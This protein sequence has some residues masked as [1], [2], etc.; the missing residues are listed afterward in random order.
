MVD[1]IG[2]IE[3]GLN[4][5]TYE[6]SVYY[7]NDNY[8]NNIT[9]IPFAVSKADISLSIEVL[10]KVYTA[11]IEG[12]VF[13]NV[14]GEY[15]VLIDNKVIKV[16]VKN[17][18]GSFNVGILSAGNYSAS[19]SFKGNDK[20]NAALN[21][22]SFEVTSTGT[23]FYIV[24]NSSEIT[25]GDDIRLSQSLPAD[26]TGSVTYKFA[27]GTVIKVVD[28][29]E[30]FVLSGLDAGSYVIYADYSGDDNYAPAQDSI[31]IIV[32][33]PV[34]YIVVS[35][36]DLTKYYGGSEKLTVNVSD[37]RGIV[38]AGKKVIININGVNYT[39]T[40]D[41]NGIASIA[42]NLTSG[43]YIAVVYVDDVVMKVKI[44][45]LA[46]VNGTDIIKV[47]RNGTQYYATF[48]D[49]Q[50]N[51]LPDGTAVQFNVNGVFYERAISGNEG[52]A[53]LNINLHQGEY[54]ITA[55][56]P[57]TGEMASNHIIV[58][59]RLVNN[60]NLVKYFRNESQY[61]VK[62]IDDD[63]NPMG[64]GVSVT[65]N[66]NGVFYTR[67]TNESGI[68]K[69][70]INLEPGDYII[71]AEYE[72]CK[73]SNSIKVLPILH[74]SDLIKAY[75]TPDQFVANLLDG[76]GNPYANQK[77]QFNING[78]FYYRTTD[79]SGN[80]RLNINLM[81]GQYIITSSYNGMNIANTVKVTS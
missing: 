19:V 4:A 44:T 55:M 57:V 72:E 54:I 63:G 35:V 3:I 23:N 42:I 17:G 46:T 15:I 30:S 64:A 27:N 71:T 59:S 52:L 20:Y 77:V 22:T 11:Y 78:V 39:R 41:E 13:A 51:Y 48:R 24:V 75:R 56:N 18:I 5:G 7:V 21:K 32:D 1:G 36:D 28:V 80:A 43:E 61:T 10:D 62:V 45:V 68:A 9:S 40:T 73:V 2:K 6:A 37:N 8:E 31:T 16:T 76:Q 12:T 66:I 49:S 26:A 69:L 14:D 65:F 38:I 81:P 53:K 25:Y 58:I 29:G 79:N 34:I 60:Y 33:K 74:A 47:F 70:N 50:G 67:Q